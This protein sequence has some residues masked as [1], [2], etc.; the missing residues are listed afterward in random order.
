MKPPETYDFCIEVTVRERDLDELDH[1]NNTVYL[2]YAESVARAHADALG[3]G[4]EKM[5]SLGG[6][7]V[8]R[9]HEITYHLPAN[10]GDMLTVAT[11][12]G[13]MGGVRAERFTG[14]FRGPSLIAEANTEWVWIALETRRAARFPVYVRNVMSTSATP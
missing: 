13:R 2:Q 9:R 4:M 10:L 6:S 7:F 3:L 1:V 14:I 12:L 5:N 8:V 11:R